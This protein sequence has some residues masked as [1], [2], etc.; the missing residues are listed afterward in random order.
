MDFHARINVS[1][2]E[3]NR[4]DWPC[5]SSHSHLIPG[6]D[7]AHKRPLMAVL[8]FGC[9]SIASGDLFCPYN[10]TFFAPPREY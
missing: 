3:S 9:P 10:N 8:L 1:V 2:W 4:L 7:R 6:Q 5:I